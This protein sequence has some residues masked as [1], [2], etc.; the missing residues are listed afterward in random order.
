MLVGKVEVSAREMSRRS[1]LV[2]TAE[3]HDRLRV[4]GH[5]KRDE[6]VPILRVDITVSD[7]E[8]RCRLLA[9][10]ITA[11]RL[12]RLQRR[13]EPLGQCAV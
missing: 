10:P 13:K 6:A 8:Q 4:I 2:E 5:G 3:L 9:A 11:C 1:H 12:R 7:H